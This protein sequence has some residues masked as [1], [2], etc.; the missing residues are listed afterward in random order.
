LRSLLESRQQPHADRIR[1][2]LAA[3]NAPAPAEAWIAPVDLSDYDSLL[4]SA[5]ST[6][7]SIEE[8]FELEAC[9]A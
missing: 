5:L 4:A 3:Q 1:Q 7:R 2:L 8:C 6:C 9:H